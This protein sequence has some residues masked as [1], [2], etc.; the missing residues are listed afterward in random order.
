MSFVDR[1]NFP[2]L[3][4]PEAHTHRGADLIPDSVGASQIAAGAVGTSEIADASVTSAKILD[5]TI[6][7]A[8][9]A[10]ANV[11]L[12]KLASEAWTNFTP[13]LD[14]G[15]AVSKT[16]NYCR[17]VKIGRTYH[18][19]GH[20]TVTSTGTL[21]ALVVITLPVAVTS[22]GIAYR[23]IGTASLYDASLGNKYLCTAELNNSAT[24]VRFAYNSMT[25]NTSL[26]VH[27]P[28]NGAIASGD[29]F[30]FTLTWEGAS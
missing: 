5:G 19:Q 14:Q 8:D 30:A 6:A 3:A 16:V 27:A 22:A 29:E 24:V 7:T 23:P 1:T 21:G 20:F 9:I 26:G 2:T 15:G 25:N 28:F 13:D 4:R 17:Y 18:M 12:A 10:D 11:T